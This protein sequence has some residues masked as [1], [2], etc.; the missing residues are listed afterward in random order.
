VTLE[1]QAQPFVKWV[2]GKRNLLDEILPRIPDVFKDYYEP[3]AGGAAVFFSIAHQL[4]HA[5][6]LDNNLELVL[7]YHTIKKIST[8]L[9]EKLHQHAYKHSENYF[10]ITRSKNPKDAIDI[11][12]RFLYLNKTCLNGLYCVNSKGVFN[13][14][15]GKYQNPNIAQE[16]NIFACHEVLQKADILFG[17]F[18]MINPK[19]GDFVYFDP[20]YHPTDE[21]SFTRYTKQNFTETD[22]VRL[23][24]FIANLHKRVVYVMLSNSKTKFI[25]DLYRARSFS[26]SPCTRPTFCELQARW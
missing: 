13:S 11:A 26:S 7:A 15:M 20:P 22:Q 14:P 16:G 5:T 19:K 9:I 6:L 2:G 25:E 8:Q 21:L 4:N 18:T 12:A 17:D 24:D 1:T 10:Y 23:R 3:F